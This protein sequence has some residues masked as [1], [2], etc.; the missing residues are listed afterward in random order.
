MLAFPHVLR[1]N[2]DRYVTGERDD[3]VKAEAMAAVE[4]TVTQLDAAQVK[5]LEKLPDQ[6]MLDDRFLLVH[7]S[8]S[9]KDEYILSTES[10]AA[11]LKMMRGKYLGTDICF[12]GHTHI[13]MVVGGG[14]VLTSFK[15][16]TAVSL[17]RLTPYLINVGAVG[18][19]RDRCPMASCGVFDAS[20]WEIKIVRVPYDIAAA[21]KSIREAGLPER[22]ALRLEGG[23]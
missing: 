2:H 16:T 6:M 11:N 18:Q 8:P 22:L 3:R 21:Q 1:G 5:S 17:E 13:P 14:K 10:I 4:W 23:T 9:D 7:G 20:K 15:E 19:P 12:F